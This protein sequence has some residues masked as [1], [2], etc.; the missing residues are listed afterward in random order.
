[1]LF[2]SSIIVVLVR[3]KKMMNVNEHEIAYSV[4]INKIFK[5]RMAVTLFLLISFVS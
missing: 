3:V 2:L 1:M 5:V 4:K